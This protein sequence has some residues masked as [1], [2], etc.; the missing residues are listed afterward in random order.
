MTLKAVGRIDAPLDLRAG[1][2]D[3]GP[4]L[5]TQGDDG[6]RFEITLDVRHLSLEEIRAMVERIAPAVR[7]AVLAA[8]GTA[9]GVHVEGSSYPSSPTTRRVTTSWHTGW[10]V[11]TFIDRETNSS[12]RGNRAFEAVM[13]EKDPRLPELY[14]V[15]WL[16]IRAL[17]TVAPIVGLWAFTT[18][19]EEE[20]HKT[21]L[22]HLDSLLDRMS[23]DG[24][25]VDHPRPTREFNT[26]RASAL[27]PTPRDWPPTTDEIQWFREVAQQYLAWR[28]EHGPSEGARKNIAKMLGRKPATSPPAAD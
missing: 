17:Q 27:H 9:A 12:I 26:I 5:I 13:S 22:G 7:S 24:Y 21:N 11:R 3:C 25:D 6:L 1:I 18:I 23:R 28:A 14:E 8:S 20:N 15:Y 19:L 10:T 2:F 4:L 16:G